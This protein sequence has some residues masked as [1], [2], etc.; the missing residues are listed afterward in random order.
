MHENQFYLENILYELEEINEVAV[1]GVPHEKWGEV[2]CAVISFNEG[3]KLT[4]EEIKTHCAKN[5]AKLNRIGIS[6]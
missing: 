2:G 4:F 1:I 6:F 3:K 5:L